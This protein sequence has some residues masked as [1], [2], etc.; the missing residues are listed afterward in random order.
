MSLLRARS[1]Q[2]QLAMSLAAVYVA[3]T[4]IGVAAL[5]YQ[6][7]STADALSKEDLNRK[8]K[9]LAAITVPDALGRPRVDLPDWL[10]ALYRSGAFLYAVNRPEGPVIA[11]SNPEAGDLVARLPVPR[12][13]PEYFRL[14]GFGVAKK[15]YFGLTV[16]L[17]SRAGPL[18]VTVARA[19]DD[20]VLVSALLREF[21]FNIAWLIPLMVAATLGIGVFAIRRGLRPL[22]EASARA[23]AI[24]PGTI[25][26]RLPE[27]SVPTEV[28][29]LVAAVNR[30]LDRLEKGF[31]VQRQFTANAA[32]ELRTPL[33]VLT[34][35]LEHLAGDGEIAKLRKDVA[36]MNRLVEQLLRVA[37]LD[38]VALDVLGTVDLGTVAGEVVA[39]MAPL[40]LANGRTIAAQG[41]ERPVLVKGNRHAIE[42]A[43]RNLVENALAYAPAGT[44][45]VVSVDAP[46]S[47]S[48]AD[49]GPGIPQGDRER[50]FDRFWRGANSPAQGSGLGLAIV[51]EIMNAHRGSV[52]AGDNPAGGAVL[53]LAFPPLPENSQNGQP[54]P[55]SDRTNEQAALGRPHS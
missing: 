10:D 6:A 7:Y 22:R 30:A 15:D 8:A 52:G 18:R 24:D 4:A 44:E 42:D 36:R 54:S 41:T 40:A 45:V 9:H 12:E 37:R 48:V 29:P 46:A 34:A 2:L 53:T 47:V 35:G 3:A 49:R 1:L 27:E 17:A 26:V 19:A 32:H 23:A 51:R 21:V 50:I 13:E 39:Y 38:A 20:D 5:L 14:R 16:R 25:S 31:A 28:Q 55:G 43:I 33:S 11:Q